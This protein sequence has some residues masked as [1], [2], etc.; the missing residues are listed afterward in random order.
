[1]IPDEERLNAQLNERWG[2]PWLPAKVAAAISVRSDGKV[3]INLAFFDDP[4]GEVPRFNA[5]VPVELWA[6]LV[7]GVAEGL[8]R[9]D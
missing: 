8:N 3:G 9:S 7:I 6:D 5:L 1:M 4:E 2:D